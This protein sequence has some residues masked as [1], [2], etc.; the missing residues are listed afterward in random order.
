MLKKSKLFANKAIFPLFIIILLTLP[1]TLS[2]Y[3]AEDFNWIPPFLARDEKPSIIIIFDNSGSMLERA[4]TEVF[5]SSREYYGYFN[6]RSYYRYVSSSSRF[7]SDNGTSGTWNG[8][9]LNWATMHRVDVARKV[10]GGGNYNT[11]NNCFEVVTQDTGNRVAPFTFNGALYTDLN[12][13]PNKR[14]TPHTTSIN[15]SHPNSQMYMT[16]GGTNYVMR[17]QDTPKEGVLHAFKDKARMSLFIYDHSVGGRVQRH[18]SEDATELN[19]VI[20]TINTVYPTTWTPLA[21]TLFTVYGYIRQHSGYNSSWG[22]R[23]LSGSQSYGVSATL[24]PFYFPSLGANVHCT[25]QNVILITDGE[26]TQDLAIPSTF[27]GETLAER[28]VKPRI[29]YPSSGTSYLIDVAHWGQTTDMRSDLPGNQT[30]DFY[31]VFAFGSGSTLLKEAARHGKFKQS[32]PGSNGNNMPD[33]VSE[34][35]TNGDGMPDNYFEAE[36]GQ[37]LEAAIFQAFQLATANIASGTAAAVTSQ[38]RSGEGAAYQA[39]FFPPTSAGQIAPPWSGQVHAFMLDARGNLREDTNGNGRL[40]LFEDRVIRFEGEY[41]FASVDANGDSVISAAETNATPLGSINDINFLWSTSPWLNAMT[42]PAAITQRYYTSTSANRHIF[43]FVDRNNNMV[44]ESGEVLP[45]THTAADCNHPDNFCSYLTLYGNNSGAVSPVPSP[46]LSLTQLSAFAQRQINFIR[47]ADVGNATNLAGSGINDIARSRTFNGSPWRLGDIIYSSPTVVGKPAE[48][49][50]LIYKDRTYEDFFKQYQNRRQMIYA[51]GN[52]GMLHAFNGG[53]YNS[54]S[55]NSTSR[56]SFQLA[57]DGGEAPHALGAELWAYVPYNLLP[58]LKW[59]MDKDYGENLHA[60]Y[61]D[62]KPRIFDARVFFQA[63]GI[64]PMNNSTHPNGWGTILV[65]GMRL[66]GAQIDIDITKNGM[67]DRTATSAYIIMDITNPEQEPT[68]LGEIA[69]PGQG[70]TTCYPTVLPMSKRNANTEAD[71]KWY[72]VFGSGPASSTGAASRSKLYDDQT[73]DQAGKLFVLDLKALVAEKTVK[74][75]SGSGEVLAGSH[76]FATTEPGSFVSDPVAVDLDIG[77]YS[78]AGE[79][80]T[81]VVYYG[82]VAGDQ[83]HGQGMLRRLLT[84]N[85]RTPSAPSHWIGNSTLINA[86]KPITSAPAVALDDSTPQRMWVYFGAGRF[87]SREDIPQNSHMAFYGVKEPI[88]TS[89]EKSWTTVT[90]ALFNSTDV[91]LDNSTCGGINRQDC[92]NVY[93]GGTLLTGSHSAGRWQNL[94]DA[95]AAAPGWRIDFNA[96][97]ERVL[98]QAA[99]LGGAVVFTSYTPSNDICSFEGS[100][101][102]WGV[103]Y[104]TGTAFYRPILGATGTTFNTFIDLGQ[105][106]ALTPNIHIGEK[107]STAFIQSSTGAIETIKIENPESVRSGTL[108]WRENTN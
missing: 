90:G 52:D 50:H 37:E 2:A 94:L 5:N 91:T 98:G 72:L 68:L 78:S 17:V 4:Y 41:V 105:G 32:G 71:N 26:S 62:L 95:V 3:K 39:L 47:G 28:I 45:F 76:V 9:W 57:W 64:T 93:K 16:I 63:D 56:G 107:G 27:G 61:V 88:S 92:V 29:N 42:D 103:Y 15:I 55:L 89:G 82:T 48:N 96:A 8:N 51:G 12:G 97:Y 31:A 108:F 79:F 66:G 53:F 58:H 59:L 46:P 19:T 80:A 77:P 13:T 21:E 67:A 49:Y 7:V 35:D 6:P 83:T 86:G 65:T 11:S 44:A 36:T 84:N 23:Y 60:A 33:L 73:S 99:V 101:K 85:I 106:M 25:K 1:L 38:T 24:D 75:V 69:M 104:K 14:M 87:F 74:S 54:T 100:S 43:T 22:P 81:D 30:V 40:D 10:M 20:N 34:W 102:L 18:M 70:F